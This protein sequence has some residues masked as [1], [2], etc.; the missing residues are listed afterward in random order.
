[1]PPRYGSFNLQ[2]TTGDVYIKMNGTSYQLCTILDYEGKMKADGSR[3]INSGHWI[4][5]SL[6]EDHKIYKCND[7]K[8]GMFIHKQLIKIIFDLN[9]LYLKIMKIKLSFWEQLSDLTILESTFNENNYL[10]GFTKTETKSNIFKTIVSQSPGK[11]IIDILEDK[12]ESQETDNYSME[13]LEKE[14]SM[15]GIGSSFYDSPG[16]VSMKSGGES[17]GEPVSMESQ[18]EPVTERHTGLTPQI[19]NLG[20]EKCRIC[21]DFKT[22]TRKA[23]DLIVAAVFKIYKVD[24]SKGRFANILLYL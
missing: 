5:W 23:S 9:F 4:T 8:I 16:S 11:S 24:L 12:S 14:S 20:S 17:F 10:F 22:G 2:A 13:S 18:T 21:Q 1:M 7:T 15:E 19:Q 6:K 3:D